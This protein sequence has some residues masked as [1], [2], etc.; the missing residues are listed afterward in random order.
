M[1]LRCMRVLALDAALA[2][3]SVTIVVNDQVIAQRQQVGDRGQATLLPV[4][5]AAVF[6]EAELAAGSLD[7]VAVTVGPGSFTGI[8]AG[9]ALAHGSGWRPECRSSASASAR[10]WR[11]RCRI[12]GGAACW[13]AID[14]RRGRVFLERDGASGRSRWRLWPRPRARLQLPGTPPSR[15]RRGWR[16]VMPT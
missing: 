7:L 10:R 6:V 16:R 15:C 11:R 2:R 4:M 8:R 5:A 12:S 9:L 3:C 1:S 13:S 14:S